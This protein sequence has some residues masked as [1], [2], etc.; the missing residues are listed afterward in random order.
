M[1]PFL[2]RCPNSGYQVQGF[3][4]EDFRTILKIARRSLVLPASGS[5][6]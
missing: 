2:Y 3:V 5:T 6:L 4:A 1:M